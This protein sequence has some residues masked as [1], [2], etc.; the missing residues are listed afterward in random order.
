MLSPDIRCNL[1]GHTRGD[2]TGVITVFAGSAVGFISDREMIHPGPFSAWL[3]RAPGDVT[4]WDGSGQ[5]WF[6]IWESGPKSFM[7]LTWDISS[8]QWQFELPATLPNGQYLLRFEHI[9]LH[10]A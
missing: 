2:K 6:R 1:N 5:Q 9:G 3:G 10:G 7:P 8:R 4:E